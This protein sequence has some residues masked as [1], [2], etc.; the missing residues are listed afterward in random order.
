MKTKQI[1]RLMSMTLVAIVSL[2][3]F[4]CSSDDDDNQGGSTSLETPKYESV[5][6][7]YEVTGN[8]GI[9]IKSIELTASGDYIITKNPYS[10]FAAPRNGKSVDKKKGLFH[11]ALAT[12]AVSDYGWIICGKYEKIDDTT[13]E[14]E[15]WGRIK[16]TGSSDHAMSI[17]VTPVGSSSSYTVPVAKKEQH[18][19]SSLTDKLCRTWSIG[20]MRITIS[21]GNRQIYNK[22]YKMTE[23]SKF[24]EDMKKLE[25]QYGFDDDEDDDYYGDDEDDDEFFDGIDN[26]PEKI[27]FT[28]SGTYMVMYSQ[29]ELAISTWRWQNESKGILHYAWNY[30]DDEYA[31]GD[32]NI[33]FRG[34]QL[35]IKESLSD[36]E[37][38]DDEEGSIVATYYL[39][40]VK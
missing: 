38:G 40:E 23:L 36:D 24:N 17:E 13:F 18:P 35:A 39:D 27:I 33:S 22:E 37:D 3:F 8:S 10:G 7:L 1:M 20:S 25:Q 31:A 5:S 26:Y 12:R 14:L 16:I 32:V 15:R 28:K 6:A 30:Y 29:E 11:K 34:N 2:G 4:S 21:F 19:N 9:D